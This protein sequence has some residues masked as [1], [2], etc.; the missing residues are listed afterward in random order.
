MDVLPFH[1]TGMR[2]MCDVREGPKARHTDMCVYLHCGCAP[3][4]LYAGNK[5]ETAQGVSH[6]TL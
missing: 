4:R 5:T 1:A 6:G 3:H 2:G